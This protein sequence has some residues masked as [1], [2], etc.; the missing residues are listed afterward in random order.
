MPPFCRDKW[1]QNRVR[2]GSKCCNC[3]SSICS[4]PSRVRARWAKMSRISE[5]A[6]EN[7]AV[8]NLLQVAALRGRKFI[9]ENDRIHVRAAAMLGKFVRLAFADESGRARRDQLLDAVADDLPASGGGQFGKFL[10]GIAGYPSRFGI[11]SSTPTRKTRSVLRFLVS[12][13][14]FKSLRLFALS[15]DLSPANLTQFEAD[16]KVIFGR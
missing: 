7:L 14:A 4:L 6:I 11:L 10:Q 1:P 9:V 13:S 12:I 5:V 3:A 2:R 8:E 15:I 16:R